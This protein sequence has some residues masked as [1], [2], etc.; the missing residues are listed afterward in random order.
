M[1][2]C[3][4]HKL[5]HRPLRTEGDEAGCLRTQPSALRVQR[6]ML[7]EGAG[8]SGT[9][10]VGLLTARFTVRVRAA[11]PLLNSGFVWLVSEYIFAAERLVHGLRG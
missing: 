1:T 10:S 6:R 7:E 5:V 9:V 4:V 3:V 8:P 11:E 2:H